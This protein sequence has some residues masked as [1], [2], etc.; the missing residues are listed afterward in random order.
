MRVRFADSLTF[1]ILDMLSMDGG[2]LTMEG[3]MLMF[4]E[5]NARTVK[6]LVSRLTARGEIESRIR[7]V[8]DGGG[9]TPW[10]YRV[11]EAG[12]ARVAA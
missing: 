9:P 11:T 4:P 6:R 3:L 12:E 1:D 7:L 8:G 10:E 2:W 5:K